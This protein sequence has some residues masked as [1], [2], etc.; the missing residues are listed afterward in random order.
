MT[1][2][3]IQD[4]PSCYGT[5]LHPRRSNPQ[6]SGVHGRLCTPLWIVACS[7][8]LLSGL[9]AA[10]PHRQPEPD[11]AHAGYGSGFRRD[12]NGACTIHVLWRGQTGGVTAQKLPLPLQQGRRRMQCRP[13]FAVGSGL[14]PFWDDHMPGLSQPGGA[15]HASH[16]EERTVTNKP[17]RLRRST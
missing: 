13:V 8:R 4:C 5:C 10:C 2:D 17:G 12:V 7:R 15:D 6:L 11:A 16:P 9:T 14:A 3:Y 1:P